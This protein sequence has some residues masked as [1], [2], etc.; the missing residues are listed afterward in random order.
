MFFYGKRLTY[1]M[2][3][4]WRDEWSR[5]GT[6]YAI[7]TFISGSNGLINWPPVSYIVIGPEAYDI[8][9]IRLEVGNHEVAMFVI[10]HLGDLVGDS[11]A[12]TYWGKAKY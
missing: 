9:G 11:F 4:Y 1:G 10:H 12:P 7:I 2:E 6:G 8:L 3:A 5:T